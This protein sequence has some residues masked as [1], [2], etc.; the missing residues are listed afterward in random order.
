MAGLTHL[1]LQFFLFL[2]E[3]L[4]LSCIILVEF[5]FLRRSTG[6]ILL[7]IISAVQAQSGISFPHLSQ[8]LIFQQTRP[9]ILRHHISDRP[10]FFWPH[11]IQPMPVRIVQTFFICCPKLLCRRSFLFQFSDPV[12][13]PL[14][15]FLCT[16]I[17]RRNIVQIA[18]VFKRLL[19]LLIQFFL[20]SIQVDKRIIQ[21]RR[22]ISRKL[23][24]SAS[25]RNYNSS[26]FANQVGCGCD[27]FIAYACILPFCYRSRILRNFCFLFT[28]FPAVVGNLRLAYKPCDHPVV[29]SMKVISFLIGFRSCKKGISLL[30]VMDRRSA[31]TKRQDVL[32]NFAVFPVHDRIIIQ[33][34]S[35]SFQH[36]EITHVRTIPA[37]QRRT[38]DQVFR[39]A[40]RLFFQRVYQFPVGPAVF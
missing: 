38:P 8:F 11:M 10:P 16:R 13:I 23:Q 26:M 25:Q 32:P 22:R 29:R 12:L 6:Q 33:I 28:V 21:K 40:F 34:D 7:R 3:R 5:V 9:R 24:L 39:I 18:P 31:Y 14:H 30:Q 19:I 37:S 1:R 35:M 27:R 15:I 36:V 2:F 4:C 20:L 17:I